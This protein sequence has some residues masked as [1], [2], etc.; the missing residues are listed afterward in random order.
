M[1]CGRPCPPEQSICISCS[2]KTNSIIQWCRKIDHGTIYDPIPDHSHLF[3]GRWYEEGVKKWG[4]PVAEYI[5]MAMDYQKKAR[6]GGL[7]DARKTID[8]EAKVS[9]PSTTMEKPKRGRK[10]KVA[11]TIPSVM[12]NVI[13]EPVSTVIAPPVVEE[14]PKKAR[15]PAVAKKQSTIKKPK[16]TTP[17]KMA[18]PSMIQKEV[19]LPTFMEQTREEID[20]DEFEVEYVKLSAFTH[21]NVTYFRDSKKNKLYKK[22]KENSVGDYVGRYDPLSQT[23]YTD[24]P[25]SDEE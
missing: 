10:P 11:E 22:I 24:V 3:G 13:T 14:K 7:L 18:D 20:M 2:V 5:E 21:D 8:K 12:E 15:K 4:E 17:V 19:I 1:R 16:V 9:V 25:D 23:I 6:E